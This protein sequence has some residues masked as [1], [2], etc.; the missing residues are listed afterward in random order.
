M[1]Y[2]V[3]TVDDDPSIHMALSVLIST[4]GAL[5]SFPPALCGPDA[6]ELASR[7]CPDIVICDVNMPGMSGLETLPLLR[8][9]CPKAILALYSADPDA[10]RGM[11]CGADAVFAK[12]DDPVLMLTDLLHR[13]RQ[14]N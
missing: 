2:S 13:A 4:E 12:S 10:G 14:H 8:E 11:E 3:L 1:P 6:I 9:R 5:V 7:E